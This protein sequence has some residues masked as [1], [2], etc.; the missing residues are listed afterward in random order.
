M[1]FNE[2]P[3]AALSQPIETGDPS[4]LRANQG[5]A[6]VA[7]VLALGG[8]VNQAGNFDTSHPVTQGSNP[9]NIQV[10]PMDAQAGTVGT[11]QAAESMIAKMRGLSAMTGELPAEKKALNTQDELKANG[12]SGSAYIESSNN[13]VTDDIGCEPEPTDTTD[14]DNTDDQYQ[15]LNDSTDSGLDSTGADT[16]SGLTVTADTAAIQSG[17]STIET[18]A[19]RSQIIDAGGEEPEATPTTDGNEDENTGDTDTDTDTDGENNAGNS[20]N[21]NLDADTGN[22]GEG[23]SAG[24]DNYTDSGNV[25]DYGADTATDDTGSANAPDIDDSSSD[26]NGYPGQGIDNG[27][28]SPESAENCDNPISDD[29]SGGDDDSVTQSDDDMA[30]D[31]TTTGP[32]SEAAEGEGEDPYGLLDDPNTQNTGESTP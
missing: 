12:G 16:D 23:D 13:S 22:W 3:T 8:A 15:S 28:E 31:P 32:V 9:S 25:S 26:G 17:S 6:V 11:K 19:V 30:D 21:N 2:Q 29:E 14:Y 5:T 20:D 24:N 1:N 10:V 18:P 7:A 4:G 27:E